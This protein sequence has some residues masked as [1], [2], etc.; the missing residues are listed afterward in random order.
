MEST[1]GCPRSPFLFNNVLEVLVCVV[2]QEQISKH[3]DLKETKL[4]SITDKVIFHLQN[5]SKFYKNAT[6]TEVNL[7]EF[8]NKVHLLIYVCGCW[9]AHH[10]CTVPTETRRGC[11]IPWSLSYRWF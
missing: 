10:V 5:A 7:E 9:S 4:P 11:Q 8:Y 6:K 2:R 1:Q 3:T